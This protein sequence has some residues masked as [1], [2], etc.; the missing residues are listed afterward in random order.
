MH[1]QSFKH[2]FEKLQGNQNGQIGA[3]YTLIKTK[4]YPATVALIADHGPEINK[5]NQEKQRMASNQTSPWSD[6]C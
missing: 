6:E 5:L 3:L 1:Q 2:T 4:K